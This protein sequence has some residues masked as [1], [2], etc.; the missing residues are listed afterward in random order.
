MHLRP[1]GFFGRETDETFISHRIFNPRNQLKPNNLAPFPAWPPHAPVLLW[2]R[3]SY[4]I[5]TKNRV[6]LLE[7]E[8]PEGFAEV[9]SGHLVRFQPTD[10]VDY[11]VVEEMVAAWWR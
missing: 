10:G 4:V 1:S 9:L 5:H 2:S 7:N 6:L 8:S 3:V 11:G